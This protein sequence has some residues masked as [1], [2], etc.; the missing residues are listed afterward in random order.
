MLL[1]LVLIS[2][3]KN[4]ES[5]TVYSNSNGEVVPVEY[6]KGFEIKQFEGYKLLV[7]NDP[8]PKADKSFTYLLVEKGANI[9]TEV[10]YDQKVDIPVQK[11][12]VT[13]T[14]HI[15]SIEILNEEQ[16]LVGFPGLDYISSN[17]VRTR[18]SKG[19]VTELGQNESINTEILISLDPDLVIGFAIDGNNK[20]F[21]TIQKSGIPVIYNGDWTEESPLGKAEWI[22]F[23]GAFYD[24]DE[25]ASLKFNEI[26][27]SYLESIELAKDA[28]IS[29]TVLSGSMYKDQ[30]YVPYGNSWQAQFI[31]DAN[32]NY[33]YKDTKG[34]GSIALS[35][36]SVLDKSKDA[37]YWVAPGQFQSFQQLL[38]TSS[39]YK[40]FKAVHDKKVFTYSNSL[41]TSGGV[42]YY[43]LA[44]TRPDLVLKDLI[45]IFHPE[46]LPDYQ[47]TFFK[48]L[49]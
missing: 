34:S 48:V 20:T 7:V 9:P 32:A 42:L 8:W 14:T 6:A 28:N 43:E 23:F 46:L 19:L 33:I 17:K 25:L 30:W 31:Q 44:P 36:E 10:Q 1:C 37:A 29:P 40:Q 11:I 45:S 27:D 21:N 35:F 16:S 12:V 38:E 2:S 5:K 26:R 4:E 41:G 39:H 24:K 3:C 15:P 49:Q 13:S 18:I 22:K 47:P